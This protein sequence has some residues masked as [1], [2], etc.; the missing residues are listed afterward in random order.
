MWHDGINAQAVRVVD[1]HVC[2]H[3][4]HR[5]RPR[6]PRGGAE[7]SGE[8]LVCDMA[9]EGVDMTEET[10]FMID[11]HVQ[12]RDAEN[13]A[14]PSGDAKEMRAVVLAGF[15]GLNKLRV[16]RKPMPEPQEGEVKIRVKAW[17]ISR[18]LSFNKHEMGCDTSLFQDPSPG[19]TINTLHCVS[20]GFCS[21]EATGIFFWYSRLAA[22]AHHTKQSC[23]SRTPSRFL[24]IA[25]SLFL[26]AVIIEWADLL[27]NSPSLCKWSSKWVFLIG[28]SVLKPLK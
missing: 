18:Y 4:A 23:F 3:A 20:E 26:N 22:G 24:C 7:R 15:G 27:P 2:A 6:K 19:W 28:A 9:K 25:T 21:H 14:G 5:P 17:W 13:V 8:Q 11:R 1:A 10:E 16:S 12:G